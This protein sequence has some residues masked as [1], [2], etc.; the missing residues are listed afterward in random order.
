MKLLIFIIILVMV[1]F[2]R[3]QLKAVYKATK[4]T[5]IEIDNKITELNRKFEAL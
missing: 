3:P 2:G 5:F 1:A 4:S